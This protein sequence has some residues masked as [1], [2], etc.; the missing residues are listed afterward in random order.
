MSNKQ[1]KLSSTERAAIVIVALGA[2]CASEV[3]KYLKEDEVEQISLEVA[4][5]K[6]VV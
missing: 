2:E 3:Y 1:H 5:R 6:S 4:D